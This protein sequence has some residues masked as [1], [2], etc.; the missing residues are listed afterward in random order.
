MTV[1][2]VVFDVGETLVDETR[3]WAVWAD[4][5][6][7]PRLTFFSMLGAVI[8]RG[9]HHREVFERFRPGID[10]RVEANR[11]GI[12]GRSD[13]LSLDDLYPDVLP[14]LRRLTEAGYRLALAGNQPAP[15][16]GILSA[17]DVPFEFVGTSAAWGVEKPSR[18]FFDRIV[19][20]LRL[21]PGDIAYVGDRVDN[22]VRPAAAAGLVAVFLRRGPWGWVLDDGVRP[23]EAAL[24]IE[25]LAELPAALG[26]LDDGTGSRGR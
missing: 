1:R 4:W 18:A 21:P 15:A 26:T 2:A 6:G 3:A 7:V 16:A 11:L 24:A 10:L 14:A 5:L 12:A 19:E 13:L 23:G 9:R 25:S 17:M 8:A 22:D 20:E